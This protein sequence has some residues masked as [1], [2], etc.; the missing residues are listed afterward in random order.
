MLPRSS[1]CVCLLGSAHRASFFALHGY[2]APDR[3]GNGGAAAVSWR[4]ERRWFPLGPEGPEQA[5][6]GGHA[7]KTRPW[8]EHAFRPGH[9][10][11]HDSVHLL[12]YPAATGCG[13]RKVSPPRSLHSYSWASVTD[14]P[15]T[16]PLVWS[17]REPVSVEVRMVG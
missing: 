11:D 10:V 17:V 14:A 2:R 6:R 9:G 13:L 4:I 16:V 8:I 7:R 12:V 15:A 5:R 3:E 1:A